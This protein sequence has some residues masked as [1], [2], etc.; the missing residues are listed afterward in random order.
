MSHRRRAAGRDPSEEQ[1]SSTVSSSN[2]VKPPKISGFRLGKITTESVAPPETDR[3]AGPSPDASQRKNPAVAGVTA[4]RT[5]VSLTDPP[6]YNYCKNLISLSVPRA[7]LLTFLI[8]I[9]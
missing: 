6:L 7:S 9:I 8:W 5:T 3:K 1:L 2:P 4:L